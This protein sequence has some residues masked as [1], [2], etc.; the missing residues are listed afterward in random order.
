MKVTCLKENLKKGLEITERITGRNSTLP[1]LSNLLITAENNGLK[2][3]ST[4]LEIGISTLLSGKINQ[5]GSITVPAKTLS[6]FI[7]NLPNKK[8]DF[9]V[10]NGILKIECENIKASINGLDAQEF[11]IIPKIKNT[12]A[13]TINS[14][15]LKNAFSEAIVS[16]AFSDARPEIT[17]VAVKI[18]PDIIK[19]VATDSFRLS[20]KTLSLKKENISFN[21]LKNKPT[22]LIVPSKTV[23][24]L[25]RIIGNNDFS[26]KIF[27]D[28]TQIMFDLKDTQVVSRLIDGQFPDYEA[29]IPKENELS[30]VCSKNN[31][32]EA[33]RLASCFSGKLSDVI[34]KTQKNRGMLKISSQDV[35]LGS[36]ETDIEADL[37][38]NDLSLIF[39]WRYLLDGLKYI[40]ADRI[41]IEFAGEQ[42]PAV[43]KPAGF[44]DFLYLLMPIRN[45]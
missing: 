30:L 17:G 28:P 25:I 10:K 23:N 29:V 7:N 12:D 41:N 22:V 37:K 24:E 1:I 31:L 32:E 40:K 16:V 20:E 21:N 4:D 9:E 14:Q 38:G 6:Q 33:V 35:S 19:F 45:H 3:V 42:K 18:E 8:I 15:I 2:I 39:N 11:P 13:L 5:T 36:H 34:I 26:V 44:Y 43:I 27:I